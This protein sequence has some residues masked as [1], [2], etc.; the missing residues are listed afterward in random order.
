MLGGL[1]KT[2]TFATPRGQLLLCHGIGRDDMRGLLPDSSRY[3][4][5]NHE[6]LQRI[7]RE[8]AFAF[9]ACGHT[10]RRMVRVVGGLTILNAGALPEE[11]GPTLLVADFEAGAAEVYDCGASV[12]L[13]CRRAL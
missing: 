12:S 2:R 6:E 8:R 10:H 9:V 1:P 13:A 7:L 5:E 4:I 3:D 11:D